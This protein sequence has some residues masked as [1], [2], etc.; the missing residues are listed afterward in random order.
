MRQNSIESSQQE[1]D[2]GQFDKY[3]AFRELELEDVQGD[4]AQ[5][6]EDKNFPI[7]TKFAI[8]QIINI[9]QKLKNHG[10]FWSDNLLLNEKCQ[11]K[12]HLREHF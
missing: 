4:T 2:E 8:S 11:Q 12:N 1:N 5:D 3:A 6:K 10:L 7:R 9:W